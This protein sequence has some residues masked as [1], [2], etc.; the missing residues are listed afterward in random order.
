MK[1]FATLLVAAALTGAVPMPQTVPATIFS[2][3]LNA[4]DSGSRPAME[5]FFKRH[6]PARVGR[7]DA[8]LAFS[9][10]TGG[11]D[12]RKV[13]KSD[14]TSITVLM[15]ERGSDEFVQ[16]S[17]FVDPAS[18]TTIVRREIV[19][20][21]RPASFT[22]PHLSID[23][24]LPQLDVRA[25]Q[26]FSAGRFAGNV[27]VA[28]DGKA[29]F[30]K[31]YGLADRSSNTPNSAA[32]KF[33]LGSMNK[34]FTAVSIVQ[35]VQAGK[36]DLDKPFGTYLP[37]YPNKSVSAAVT[38]RQLLTHTGGTGD[39]FG[40]AFDKHR[41]DLKTLQDYVDLYGSR[42]LLFAPGSKW[43]Y[44]NFGYILLGAVIEKVSGENYYSYVREHI[45][46]PA[47]MH[48]TESEPESVPVTNR[49]VG[50][51]MDSGQL[52]PNTDSLPYRGTSA[53]GGYSTTAD[54]L[55][56]ANALQS[57]RLLDAAHTQMLFDGSVKTPLGMDALGF[58][59]Q[60]VNGTTCLGHGGGADGM[61][62]ELKICGRYTVVVLANLD[63]PAATRIAD[64]AANRLPSH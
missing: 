4:F 33:R 42:P 44:S 17:L 41:L 3:W 63:P 40:P 29:L 12:V 55:R 31:S 28:R 21:E 19:P 47:G 60:N 22:L 32:S 1:R 11:F 56:F 62:G 24:L 46:E 2:E 58:F 43:D 45:Y 64:F 36:L 57:H 16:M 18:P 6:S 37:D 20:A 54:L 35:L 15:Q 34:M 13:V 52:R 53:G 25:Q 39:I 38:L 10:T 14:A 30:S 49:T 26:D 7:T 48:D 59:V 50:Y 51:T 23:A 5:A 61:N 9:R 8:E 27:L